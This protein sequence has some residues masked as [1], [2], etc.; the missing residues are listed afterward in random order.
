MA[1]EEVVFP[2]DI[3][4]QI[5]IRSDVEA[6]VQFKSVCKSWKSLICDDR[7]IKAHMNHSYNND[8]NNQKM[9]HRRIV[10]SRDNMPYNFQWY[11]LYTSKRNL[12][13]SSNGL[14]CISTSHGEVIV[15]N[16][17]TRDMKKLPNPKLFV[18]LEWSTCWGFGYDSSTDDYKV[19]VGSSSDY[20]R[21]SFQ[22]LSLKTNV[23]KD[24][25]KLK[26]MCLN[27]HKV[28]ILC[29]EKLHWFMKDQNGKDVILS[30]DLSEEKFEEISQPRV[31][32]YEPYFH[33][34]IIDECL[35]IC[36]LNHPVWVMK[37]Y[38]V[39]ESWVSLQYPLK[40]DNDVVHYLRPIKDSLSHTS[41]F[42]NDD[43]IMSRIRDVN[44]VP[45]FV[46]S[47]VSPHVFMGN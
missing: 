12:I 21:M 8:R 5:L 1:V 27:V 22:V 43:M 24:V 33:M 13:G 20:L 40:N 42:T 28:G 11:Y 35:C 17:L 32:K 18:G 31:F 3:I 25:G 15:A 38:N 6:L 39:R 44:Y 26:Y 7:F 36:D 29:N 23:W 4:E 37:N 16:P 14:V 19:I 46:R 47:L 9:G 34:G 30:F 2:H 45:I 10:M 41:F